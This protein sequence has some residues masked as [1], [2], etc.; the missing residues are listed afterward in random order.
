M[1]SGGPK[2]ERGKVEVEKEA[3]K[4]AAAPGEKPATSAPPA[5][6]EVPAHLLK[7]EVRNPWKICFLLEIPIS[8]S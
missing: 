6:R 4:A 5:V 3:E 8:F 7:P 1:A 2:A